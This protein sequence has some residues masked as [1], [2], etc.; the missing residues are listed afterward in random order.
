MDTTPNLA[1]PYILASQAQKHVT[2]NEALRALDAVVQISIVDRDLTTPPASPADGDRYI[3]AVGATAGWAG[4]DRKIAA[5]QDGTWS[6]YPP[7]EG[8]LAWVAD[9]N[10]LLAFDGAA[11][12]PAA[13]AAALQ[14]VPMLGINATADVTN[15]LALSAAASLF[16]HAGAGHQLNINKAASGDSASLHYQSN[17]SGRAE[18]G[19][20][21]DDDLHI[22]VSADGSTWADAI[23]IDRNTGF[24]NFGVAPVAGA[25]RLTIKGDNNL[26]SQAKLWQQLD[27]AA[28]GGGFLLHH[29]RSSG[30]PQSGDRLGYLFFGSDNAGVNANGAGI[31]GAADGTWTYGS[32]HPT[33]FTFETTPTG[34]TT[35]V[36]R[37]RIDAAG[38]VGI[39][40]TGPAC[41]L[42]VDGPV[43]VKSYT[44]AGVPPATAGAGQI[45]FVSNES[46]GAVLAF[47]DGTNWR[48]VTDRAVI[49]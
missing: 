45:I 38:N 42:D 6:F 44:V 26:K 35:R 37:M 23:I 25:S 49:S 24:V 10:V 46:G 36:E 30:A 29:N 21:G 39:G 4:H 3:V 31:A 2:H 41:K 1:L 34:S 47:S 14:N 12:I 40:L 17:L 15:R 11:W 22:K 5:W 32:S 28:G 19:L 18:I 7:V 8:W 16:N 13:A 43:R 27:T 48:R 9:E 20:M 33:R